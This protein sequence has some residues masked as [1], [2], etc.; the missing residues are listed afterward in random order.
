M[1][2]FLKALLTFIEL[3]RAGFEIKKHTYKHVK[4]VGILTKENKC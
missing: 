3:Y 4:G 2:K 1:Y